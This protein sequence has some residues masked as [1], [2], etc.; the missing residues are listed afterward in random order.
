[1]NKPT[2]QRAAE[3]NCT[4][5]VEVR[6][7]VCEAFLCKRC[8]DSTGCNG[9]EV[10]QDREILKSVLSE[11]INTMIVTS[12]D[13][14][15]AKAAWNKAVV[16]INAAIVKRNKIEEGWPEAAATF[17]EAKKTLAIQVGWTW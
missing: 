10:S 13:F 11:H 2:C 12:T 1:M 6:C 15:A 14:I 8:H 7:V 9:H 17:A 3:H 5:P 16:A 4:N